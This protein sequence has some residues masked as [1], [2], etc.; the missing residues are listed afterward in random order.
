M[1]LR[2]QGLCVQDASHQR[3]LSPP[4]KPRVTTTSHPLHQVGPQP[5]STV[6]TPPSPLGSGGD[7]RGGEAG[8]HVSRRRPG[9]SLPVNFY[10]APTIQVGSVLPWQFHPSPPAGEYKSEFTPTCQKRGEEKNPKKHSCR[11]PS[12]GTMPSEVQSPRIKQDP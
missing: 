9:S 10:E 8:R 7:S 3:G 5:P 12:G 4:S 11:P 6:S 1:L 2:R